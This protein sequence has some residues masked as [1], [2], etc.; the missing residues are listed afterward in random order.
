MFSVIMAVPS[1]TQA[2]PMANGCTSVGKP[3]NGSVA[4]LTIGGTAMINTTEGDP[5]NVRSGPGID[6]G[7]VAKVPSGTL[8]TILEGPRDANGY[9]WW[10]IRLP[11]SQEGWAVESADG[12]RTL[13]P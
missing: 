3:G 8:V 2:K 6:F 4:T 9:T 11:G 12:V 7:I 10:R 1:E 13:L 5:L